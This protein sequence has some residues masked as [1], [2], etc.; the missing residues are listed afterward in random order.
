MSNRPSTCRWGVMGTANIARKVVPAMHLA[1]TAAPVAIAS[2]QH[3]G[4]K[5]DAPTGCGSG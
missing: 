1:P 3:E 2:V 4:P 5:R